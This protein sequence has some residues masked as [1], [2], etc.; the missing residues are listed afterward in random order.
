MTPA[1]R[2]M[3]LDDMEPVLAL[4]RELFPDPWTVEL[5]RS[6]LEQADTRHF[7]VAEDRS[8]LV[9]YAGLAA[10]PPDHAYVQTIGVTPGWQR[11]RLGTRLLLDLMNDAR[12]RAVER[13]GLEVRVDNAAAQALYR[14][15][16]FVPVGLRRAY[17][18]PSGTDALVMFAED[19][20]TPAYGHRL[21]AI[22]AVLE[23]AQ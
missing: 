20:G 7:V 23:S 9:G 4:E 2:P 18:Q 10:Y 5:L 3:R 17:Y 22:S 12:H 1:I 15:F 8:E 6:E 13:V 21:A 11:R 19:I 16:G 14:R